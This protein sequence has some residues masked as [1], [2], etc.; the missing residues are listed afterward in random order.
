MTH[1]YTSDNSLT[2]TIAMVTK[3]GA[4]LRRL[5]EKLT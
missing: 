5:T 1:I 3:I 2:L 4:N